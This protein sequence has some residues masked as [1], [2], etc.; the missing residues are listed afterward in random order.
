MIDQFNE[1]KVTS[2]KFYSILLHKIYPF[3]DRND[4]TCKIL[5]A[6][7]DIIK[8]NIQTNLNMLSYC[9]K[10][11]KDTESKNPKVAR[12]KNGRK[13]LLSKYAVCDRKKSKFIKEEEASGLLSSLGIKPSLN[14]IALLS[15]LLI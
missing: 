4:R 8:Q 2:T 13:M 9:L 5:F 3:F 15:P 7:D 11:R 6:S 1:R 12:T 10:S 14:K